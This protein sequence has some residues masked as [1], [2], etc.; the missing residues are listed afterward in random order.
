MTLTHI[1]ESYIT[2]AVYCKIISK[3]IAMDTLHN[4]GY[5]FQKDE[6]VSKENDFL[7]EIVCFYCSILFF[8]LDSTKKLL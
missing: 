4:F 5:I 7:C 2:I 3:L 6:Y 1:R 8:L